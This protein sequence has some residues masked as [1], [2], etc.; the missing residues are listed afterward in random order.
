[1]AGGNA[2]N[3]VIVFTVAL[4]SFTY[5]YNSSI[6]GSVFGLP[7]F[8]KYFNLSLDGTSAIVGGQYRPHA[9]RG[10]EMLMLLST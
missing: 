2:Y 8:F 6:I 3:F 5:G 4:G 7:S 9:P 10:S 1:M